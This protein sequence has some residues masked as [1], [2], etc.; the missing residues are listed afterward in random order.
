MANAVCRSKVRPM[1]LNGCVSASL[2]WLLG[3]DVFIGVDVETTASEERS[4]CMRT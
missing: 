2:S 4:V 3:R 1:D